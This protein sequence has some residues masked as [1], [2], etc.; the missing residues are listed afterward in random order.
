MCDRCNNG[1]WPISGEFAI[2]SCAFLIVRDPKPWCLV[3]AKQGADAISDSLRY[4]KG[5]TKA[6]YAFQ[7]V[8]DLPYVEADCFS[9]SDPTVVP[10]KTFLSQLV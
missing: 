2:R 10:A 9:R 3:E 6:P 8:L 1:P 4:F 5:A 7:V